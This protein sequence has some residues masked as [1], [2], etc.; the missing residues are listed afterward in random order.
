MNV[1]S[2]IAAF[3]TVGIGFMILI[4]FVEYWSEFDR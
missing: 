4:A 1:I 2:L 3:W